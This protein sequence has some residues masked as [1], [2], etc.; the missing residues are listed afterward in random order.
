MGK[1][2][3]RIQFWKIQP[4]SDIFSGMAM[5]PVQSDEASDRQIVLFGFDGE[6]DHY[7]KLEGKEQNITI[8]FSNLETEAEPVCQFHVTFTMDT[9][10][11]EKTYMAGQVLNCEQHHIHVRKIIDTGVFLRVDYSYDLEAA[12]KSRAYFCWM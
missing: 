1:F 7:S 4:G 6:E 2:W 3:R 9:V 5:I 10:F 11:P 12:E 8:Q